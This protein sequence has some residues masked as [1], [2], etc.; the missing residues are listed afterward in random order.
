MHD[1]PNLNALADT[2]PA[3]LITNVTLDRS[4]FAHAASVSLS[5]ALLSLLA[6]GGCREP[7]QR[8]VDSSLPP[9][10]ASAAPPKPTA[11]NSTGIP[12]IEPPL[13]S[14]GERITA[15]GAAMGTCIASGLVGIYAIYKLYSG[16]WVIGMPNS[17]RSSMK[18][19][20]CRS[21]TGAD[22]ASSVAAAVAAAAKSSRPAGGGSPDTAAPFQQPDRVEDAGHPPVA[23]DRRPRHQISR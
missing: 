9:L 2:L 5:L 17:S 6:L 1:A 12:D 4:P 14:G 22:A 3:S 11:S 13:P 16:T 7:S 8:A 19:S 10:G 23:Q 18:V 15:A 20:R 21:G